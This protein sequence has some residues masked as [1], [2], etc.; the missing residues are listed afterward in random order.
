MAF[1]GKLSFN[2]T[3]DEL[4]GNLGIYSW[5]IFASLSIPDFDHEYSAGRL[6]LTSELNPSQC[7][8]RQ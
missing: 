2:P 5:Y 7:L 4:E 3:K 6:D 1:S 8:K